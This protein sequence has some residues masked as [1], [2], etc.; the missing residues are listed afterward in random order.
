MS[1]TATCTENIGLI[2]DSKNH[3]SCEQSNMGALQTLGYI[4]LDKYIERLNAPIEGERKLT[5]RLYDN[6]VDRHY[7]HFNS[8]ELHQEVRKLWAAVGE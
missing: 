1:L 3:V 5:L 8:Q 7:L 2:N 6:D 4:H